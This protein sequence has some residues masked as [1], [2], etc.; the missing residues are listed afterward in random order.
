MTE[1]WKPV[2]GYEEFYEVSDAGRVRSLTRRTPVGVRVGRILKPRR[3]KNGGHRYVQL[4]RDGGCV[5][6]TVHRLVLETFLGPR[7]EGM[8]ACHFP[9]RDPGNNR[10]ANL[11]WD[12]SAANKADAVR[13]GTMGGSKCRFS[14]YNHAEIRDLR[15]AGLSGAEISKRTGISKPHLWRILNDWN[16]RATGVALS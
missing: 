13:H 7:P 4:C 9:D 1:S 16:W 6:R 2:V 3:H 15:A 8:E 12:T 10:L 14:K 5:S 11:R